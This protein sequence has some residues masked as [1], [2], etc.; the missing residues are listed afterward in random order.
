MQS[1]CKTGFSITDHIFAGTRSAIIRFRFCA[2]S[3]CDPVA[4]QLCS[5]RDGLGFVRR[6][7]MGPNPAFNTDLNRH[8]RGLF[9]ASVG[10]GAERVNSFRAVVITL[11][12]SLLLACLLS[13]TLAISAL[14]Q[15]L[16][17]GMK[18]HR[19]QAG[20][21]DASG[22]MVAASTEGGFSVRLPIKF[23]DFT[24][25]ESD[26]KAP[27]LRTFVVGT[28]SQEGIKFSAT[29][30]VYRKGAESA[31][32]FFSRIEKGK[33]LG[34]TPERI[35]PHRIGERQAVD[36]M[37]SRASDVSYQ[38]VV[39]LESDLLM[40]IVESPRSHDAIAREFAMPFFD[41]LVVVA[42]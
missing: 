25:A 17:P 21:P 36:F 5:E 38:R 22:W 4:P 41:S 19:L 28:K 27:A 2:R 39:M 24:I 40:M 31:K 1:N 9:P 37:L 26:P 12:R 7:R 15:S 13:A 6:V 18:M 11:L 42:R 32:Y 16:P 23:N 34:L 35:T 29:R 10:G 33:D 3:L 8:R 14:A 30:I 20:E